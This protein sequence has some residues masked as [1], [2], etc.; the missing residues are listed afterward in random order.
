[1]AKKSLLLILGNQLFSIDNIKS[2]NPDKIFMAEDLGL[3]TYE[4]HH[5]FRFFFSIIF[6]FH[7]YMEFL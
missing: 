6:M 5:K 1:M 7:L 2:L 4:N 3:S